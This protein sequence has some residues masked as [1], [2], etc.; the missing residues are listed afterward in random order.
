MSE[1]TIGVPDKPDREEVVAKVISY[2]EQQLEEKPS[3]PIAPSSNLVKDL[4]LDSIQSFEMVADLEDHYDV[5][6]PT[7]LF[8]DVVTVE[9]VA[10]K[11][12][13]VLIES[14]G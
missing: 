10:L 12:H 4:R 6:I 8:E 5:S 14:R 7:E 9:D 3:Q 11:I 1:S 13:S 2:L